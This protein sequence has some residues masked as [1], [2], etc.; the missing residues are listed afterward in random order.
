ML[1]S[2]ELEMY[3]YLYL[4]L[5][6]TPCTACTTTLLF[7]GLEGVNAPSGF[8]QVEMKKVLRCPPTVQRVLKFMDYSGDR[9]KLSFL[10]FANVGVVCIHV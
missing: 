3:K 10:P 8:E 1:A 4:D 2:K 6:K 7:S 5:C 9:Y